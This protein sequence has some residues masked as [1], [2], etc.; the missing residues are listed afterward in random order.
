MSRPTS[1]QTAGTLS[2]A[3]ILDC[4]TVQQGDRTVLLNGTYAMADTVVLEATP[5][6]LPTSSFPL[7][8]TTED[9]DYDAALW[10]PY[11]I[12]GTPP[13]IINTAL[14]ASGGITNFGAL[15]VTAANPVDV[16]LACSGT[17]TS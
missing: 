10:V 8:G 6:V 3:L 15:R 12:G 9:S 16:D 7:T 5:E 11:T 14:D 4:R 1:V 17:T 2:E 13:A